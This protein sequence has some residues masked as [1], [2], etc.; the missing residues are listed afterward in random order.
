MGHREDEMVCFIRV[1]EGLQQRS[2]TWTINMQK[3]DIEGEEQADREGF[4][5]RGYR[6]WAG[7]TTLGIIPDHN[8]CTT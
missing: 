6:T 4:L 1:P 5:V 8:F 3:Q 7:L 2:G